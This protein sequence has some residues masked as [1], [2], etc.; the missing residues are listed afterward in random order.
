MD[1]FQCDFCLLFDHSFAA[2]AHLIMENAFPKKLPRKL[3]IF[4][5]CWVI[6]WA[7]HGGMTEK[8]A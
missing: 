3:E 5:L 1:V 2:A 8:D 7:K 4:R 6:T